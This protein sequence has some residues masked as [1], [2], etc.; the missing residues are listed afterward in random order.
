M[1]ELEDVVGSR[2]E[3]EGHIQAEAVVEHVLMCFC[4]QDP[5]VSLEPVVQ[6]PTK[7]VPEAAQVGVRETVKLVAE[8]FECQPEG[9]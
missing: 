4:S 8:R 7:E 5:Q 1:S 2:L 3:V 6:G 9:A